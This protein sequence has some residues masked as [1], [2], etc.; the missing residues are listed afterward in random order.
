MTKMA[1]KERTLVIDDW[2][3]A[4]KKALKNKQYAVAIVSW[5]SSS[6]SPAVFWRPE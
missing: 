5:I 1:T 4:C 2:E 6:G 3:E